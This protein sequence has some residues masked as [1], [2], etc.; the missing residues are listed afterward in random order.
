MSRDLRAGYVVLVAAA[1]AKLGLAAHHD[2][3]ADEAYYWVWSLRPAFGYYDQPPLTAWVL[4]AARQLGDHALA[5]RLPGVLAGALA[6]LGL[7]PYARRRGLFLLW[8]AA[9]PPFFWLGLFATPDALLLPAWTLA[10]AGALRGGRGWL[11]AGFGGGLAFLAK[12]TGAAVLPLL[13]LAADPGERRSRWPWLGLAIAAALAAPNIVWNAAHE[14]VTFAFQLREGLWHP[15]APGPTGPL[16]VLGQQLGV[17]TPV[18]AIAGLAWM[19]R[20]PRGRVDRML[21]AASAPLLA[22]FAVAAIGGPPDAHWPAPA[23]IAVGLGLSR[24]SERLARLAGAGALVA[25]AFDVLLAVHASRPLVDLPRDPGDRLREGRA[26]ARSVAPLLAES[27]G[28]VFTERYQE[29]ALLH[30]HLGV[31]ARTWPGCGRPNQ[32]DLE[33]VALPA[34]AWMVRPA[35]SGPDLCTDRDRPARTGAIELV[36]LDRDGRRVGRWQAFR[37]H[38]APPQPE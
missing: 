33:P 13:L 29:A 10:L 12:H 22:F 7:L 17:V 38:A 27:P 24:A 35:T 34:A 16:Q 37:I 9:L 4:A 6:P 2:V 36:G 21:W 20:R 23:W 25:L 15:H 28:P 5:L 18:A 31:P 30:W 8:C 19:A 26:L 11:V 32:Y 14:G 3:L 1:A